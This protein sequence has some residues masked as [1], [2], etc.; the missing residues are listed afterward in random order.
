LAALALL[1]LCLA[2]R[3]CLLN[4]LLKFD[5]PD[6]PANNMRTI[7]VNNEKLSAM[8]RVV[9]SER[10]RVITRPSVC[11]SSE[12]FVRPTQVI[13]IFGSV[14]SHLVPWPSVIFVKNFTVIVSGEPLR[15]GS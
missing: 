6:S 4:P 8:L 14:S 15:L 1:L 7:V 11:L 9:F 13:E 3:F 5:A 2:S 10:E 12:T